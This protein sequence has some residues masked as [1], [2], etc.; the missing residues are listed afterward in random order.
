MIAKKSEFSQ[1]SIGTLLLMFILLLTSCQSNNQ[2]KS[3]LESG[4]FDSLEFQ[5]E[6]APKWTQVFERDSGWFGGDGI[7]T[8]PYTGNDRKEESDSILFLFSDTMF[9]QIKEDDVLLPGYKMVHNSV[10]LYNRKS[11]LDTINF[12]IAEN[13]QDK[14]TSIFIPQNEK[15]IKNKE[16]YWLGDGFINN[17]DSKLYLFAYRI[18]DL[19]NKDAQFPFKQVGNDLIVVPKNSDF[20]F[21][22]QRQLEIPFNKNLQDSLKISFGSAVL[23]NTKEAGESQVD[24][25]LYIYGTRSKNNNEVVS[26]RVKPSELENFNAWKFWDGKNWSNNLE[27]SAPL[28]NQVSNELSVTSLPNGQYGLIYQYGGIYPT[29]YLQTGPTPVGPFGKRIKLWD[30]SKD[31]TD[32]DLYTYN[33]KAHPAISKPGELLVS[34]NVNSFKFFDI[35]EAKPHLYHPRFIRIKFNPT[36]N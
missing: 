12:K 4:K 17:T 30:T 13:G 25:Y 31:I 2:K 8:I 5:V 19:E 36:N 11:S 23:V 20:P 27:D 1:T 35:I 9:G 16:Y 15:A 10:A 21:R 28:S 3:S 34:Y 22:D 6:R 24:G 18:K 26:A 7:F 32:P 29:I 14:P 33:A